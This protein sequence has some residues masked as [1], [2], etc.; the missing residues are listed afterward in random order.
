MAVI[1]TVF[2]ALIS[3]LFG[4]SKMECSNSPHVFDDCASNLNRILWLPVGVIPFI[5]GYRIGSWAGFDY[6]LLGIYIVACI[7]YWYVASYA[8]ITIFDFL[9]QKTNKK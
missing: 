3:I 7:P 1:F 2:I 4:M 6:R 9:R 8:L 5:G